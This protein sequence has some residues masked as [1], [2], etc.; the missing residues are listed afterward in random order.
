MPEAL[1]AES[2]RTEILNLN[3]LDEKSGTSLL[4]E[5]ARRRDIKL[6]EL[7]VKRGAD[8]FARDKKG[9]RVLEGEKGADERI[10]AF[11]RQCE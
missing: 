5:A 11:L 7:A 9:R 4:H 10:K 8:V 6:V 3:A 2:C 1:D